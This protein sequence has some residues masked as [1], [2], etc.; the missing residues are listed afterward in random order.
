MKKIRC[1]IETVLAILMIAVLIFGIKNDIAPQN[2]F[3]ETVLKPEGTWSEKMLASDEIVQ[4]EYDVPKSQNEKNWIM[5]LKT[6]WVDFEIFADDVSLY[7]TEGK[8]TGFVHLFEVPTGTD[9]SIFSCLRKS[10]RCNRAVRFSNR[11]SKRYISYDFGQ[12][13]SC[14]YICCVCSSVG[15]YSHICRL[16]YA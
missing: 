2:V 14:W 11:K 4:Y 7:R 3:N 8:R 15:I 16:L 13:Y 6:H 9:S 12:K 10:S 1:I 5:M